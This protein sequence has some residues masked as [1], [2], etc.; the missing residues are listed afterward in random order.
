MAEAGPTAPATRLEIDAVVRREERSPR[1][2][3]GESK[4]GQ[5]RDQR[6]RSAGK[7][8][9]R[10]HAERHPFPG[11]CTRCRHQR[12]RDDA[13]ERAGDVRGVGAQR[14]TPIEQPTV[15]LAG[16]VANLLD[17][18]QLGACAVVGNS[19]GGR[20]ALELAVGR[21]ELVR[22]LVLVGSSHAPG[23]M[24]QRMP[25]S[26]RGPR[27]RARRRARARGAGDPMP[28]LSP[29]QETRRGESDWRST[30]RCGSVHRSS[31]SVRAP[32]RESQT[33]REL[34][35]RR[36]RH[37]GRRGRRRRS[38][39]ARRAACCSSVRDGDRPSRTDP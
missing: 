17:G 20:V 8:E 35:Q 25:E 27:S 31:G 15:T 38:A 13:G 18:L 34:R 21:P 1:R 7:P 2:D 5:R 30:R 29:C 33:C 6:E 16:E 4:G 11:R 22:A 32:A 14:R 36:G 37:G 10:Q 12:D 3:S 24:A 26:Q 19:L 9:H 39:R 28:P 23:A